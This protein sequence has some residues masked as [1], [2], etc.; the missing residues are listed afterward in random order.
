MNPAAKVQCEN[1]H[2][3]IEADSPKCPYCG[4]SSA[5]GSEKRYM[6][7]LSSIKEGV[8]ELEQIPVKAYRKEMS[9]TGK[10]IL[11]TML[12]FAIIAGILGGLYWCFQT[13]LY[14][15]I[16]E[17][18]KT[19]LMWERE[20]YPLLDEM[21]AKGDYDGILAFMEEHYEEAGYSVYNWQHYNFIDV[22]RFYENC[23]YMAGMIEEG[24][25]NEEDVMWCIVDALFV[26]REHDYMT[27]SSQEEKQIE[28][29]R[30]EVFEVMKNLFGMTQQE[31]EKLYQDSCVEE[32]YGIIFDYDKAKKNAE[33]IAKEYSRKQ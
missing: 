28:V 23:M 16:A 22:Y 13:L 31:V 32:D 33:K 26:L 1:C 14:D 6:E 2:A 24:H 27:Y 7:Q 15:A 8:E 29:Y 19:Q 3:M 17:D 11:I 10:I 9:R 20:N 5:L 30:E 25:Y 12:V 4:A 21:Y 18:P